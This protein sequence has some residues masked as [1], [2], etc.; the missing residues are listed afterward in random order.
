MR[1][2]GVETLL[3]YKKHALESSLKHNLTYQ[4]KVGILNK[5]DFQLISLFLDAENRHEDQRV[6]QV[7]HSTELLISV[8]RVLQGVEDRNLK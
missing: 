8:R 4:N 6:Q 7:H 2:F 1:W 5:F 3:K